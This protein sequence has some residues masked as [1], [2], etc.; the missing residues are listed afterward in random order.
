MSY[1]KVVT[2]FDTAEHAEF[3]RR[4]LENAGFA[5]DDISIVGKKGLADNVLALREPGLWH[6]LFGRDI[7]EYEAKVFGKTV[8]GGGAVLTLRVP[9]SQL[10]KAMGILNQH[11]VVDI[12]RRAVETG[13]M[14]SS[15]VTPAPMPVKTLTTEVDKG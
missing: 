11:H 3:A 15:E 1:E 2:L 8:E 12:S 9:D 4:N 10:A 7:A 13:L 5:A 14:A 6:K